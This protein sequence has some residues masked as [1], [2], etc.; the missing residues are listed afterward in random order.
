MRSIFDLI[1]AGTF[2]GNVSFYDNDVLATDNAAFITSGIAGC[3]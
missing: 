1:N 3:L 2:V